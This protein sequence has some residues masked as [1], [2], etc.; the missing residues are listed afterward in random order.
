MAQPVLTAP[1]IVKRSSDAASR[2]PIR[3]SEKLPAIMPFVREA[4]RKEAPLTTEAL[5][6]PVLPEPS[7]TT[8]TAADVLAERPAPLPA[9]GLAESRSNLSPFETSREL[10]S[11]PV[12]EKY[13]EI[14]KFK[15][16]PPA[17]QV[18]ERISQ[19]GLPTILAQRRRLWMNSYYV[20]VGP[21]DEDR[22]IESARTKLVSRGFP[23]RSYEKGARIMTFGSGL[24]L[25]GASVPCGLCTVSWEAYDSNASVKFQTERGG[26]LQAEGKLV[27]RNLWY[28]RN[29]FVY[30]ISH[31]GSRRL[32]EIR[33]A[34][35]DQALVFGTAY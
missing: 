20:L 25:N 14:G 1:N 34:S 15:D 11:V 26:F 24:M 4:D 2:L 10:G 19:L 3:P 18:K 7:L 23:A 16:K 29:A 33:L 28:D 17:E 22:D 6:P 13:L 8:P 9:K 21:F 30:G 12:P 32:L 5:S 27:R 35:T 31:D